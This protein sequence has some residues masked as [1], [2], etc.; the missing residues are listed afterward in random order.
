MRKDLKDNFC[1]CS[2]FTHSRRRNHLGRITEDSINFKNC[3]SFEQSNP[4]SWIFTKAKELDISLRMFSERASNQYKNKAETKTFE[5]GCLI[6]IE[7]MKQYNLPRFIKDKAHLQQMISGNFFL[8]KGDRG[9]NDFAEQKNLKYGG[10]V[11]VIKPVKPFC[12]NSRVLEEIYIG[13]TWKTLIERFIEHTKDA[14]NAYIKENDFPQR[15]IE[16]LILKAIEEY[17][18]TNNKIKLEISPLKNFIENNLLGKKKWRKKQEI[19]K[20]AKELFNSYFQMDVLEVHRNY[21]TAWRR[22]RWN[23]ENYTRKV[24]GTIVKGTLFPKGLNMVRTSEN[25]GHRSLPLYDIIFTISQGYD[26]IEINAMLKMC[27]NINL[28][29]RNIYKQLNKFWKDWETILDVFFRPVLQKLLEDENLSWEEIAEALQRS[30]SYRTKTNFRKWFCGLN[31][32]QI[33]YLVK[34]E[35]F[36]WN[37]FETMAKEYKLDLSDQ[38]I[39][40]RIPIDVWEEWLIRDIGMEVIGQKLGYKNV[41]SFRSAWIKQDRV[42]IYQQKFGKSYSQAVMKYRRKRTIDLLTDKDFINTLLSKRLYWIYVNEFKFKNWKDYA[43]PRPSQGLRNCKNFF[44]ILFKDYGL[45]AGELESIDPH[46]YM[47]NIRF[48]SAIEE[49]TRS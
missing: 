17:L 45:S 26:G 36:N 23:I 29:Y 7:A 25:P 1:K 30:P 44:N 18:T 16:R 4:V 37:N 13:V 41:E 38:N 12:F 33:R 6:L 42:S 10:I 31:V 11:Y 9:F 24:N 27:Y 48:K 47:D 2:N 49:F 28:N 22:E 34:M 5:T 15:L 21:E 32:S 39:V 20:L 43:V 35:D 19:K 14:I 40:K 3:L 46:K 8:K